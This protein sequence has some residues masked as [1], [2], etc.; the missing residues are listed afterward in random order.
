MQSRLFYIYKTKPI[1]IYREGISP[2]LK[3]RT[4]SHFSP[5]LQCLESKQ[6]KKLLWQRAQNKVIIFSIFFYLKK[7]QPFVLRKS[8]A[9]LGTV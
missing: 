6:V 1:F 4:E 2:T 5:H 7:T 8:Q 3:V 9:L